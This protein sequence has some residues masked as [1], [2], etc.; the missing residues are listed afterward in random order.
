M[1]KESANIVKNIIASDSQKTQWKHCIYGKKG[2]F[3]LARLYVIK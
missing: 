1:T 3:S 2:N